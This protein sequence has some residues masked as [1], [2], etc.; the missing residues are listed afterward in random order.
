MQNQEVA[1]LLEEPLEVLLQTQGLEVV[2]IQYLSVE[3]SMVLRVFIDH[4]ELGVNLN[5]C[6]QASRLIS[7]WLDKKDPLPGGSYLL[8]VSS[9]GIDR[10]LKKD[11]DFERFMGSMVKVRL[12][13]KVDGQ[14]NLI[15]KLS[16]FDSENI[17]LLVDEKEWRLPREIAQVRLEP[18]L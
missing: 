11:R 16:A 12:K 7:E 3:G 2:D 5:T 10:V 1:A 14:R 15:G 9:P 13:Q 6:A 4:P 8:E 17:F 18:E